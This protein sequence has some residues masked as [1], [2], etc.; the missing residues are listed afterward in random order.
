MSDSVI[1]WTVAHQAP[2]SMGFSRQEYGVGCH[3]LLQG[4]FPTQG[5]NPGLPPCRQCFTV[6]V[7]REFIYRNSNYFIHSF[8]GQES[9]EYSAGWVWL[10]CLI[11]CSQTVVEVITEELGAGEWKGALLESSETE[12]IWNSLELTMPMSLSLI[13]GSFQ[14]LPPCWPAW[15]S[16]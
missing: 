7:T 11:C 5:L 1:P 8:L 12:Q 14:R 10:G 15:I 2:L 3:S 4:I 9:K 13:S 6:W 16:S